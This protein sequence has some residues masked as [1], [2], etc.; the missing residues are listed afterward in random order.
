[1]SLL[2]SKKYSVEI[3]GIFIFVLVLVSN[4]AVIKF[5]EG[6][7]NYY[8]VPL[9][10][11]EFTPQ[12]HD[13][14]EAAVP[15]LI[16]SL[17]IVYIIWLSFRI[18]ENLANWLLDK[19]NIGLNKNL[20]NYLQHHERL[21]I[22]IANTLNF[23]ITAITIIIIIP[24][25]WTTITNAATTLGEQKAKNTSIMYSLSTEDNIKQEIIIHTNKNI[26]ITK[27]YDT[28]TR[29][30]IDGYRILPTNTEYDVRLI[31]K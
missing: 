19:M 16:V 29:K 12:I 5:E 20:Q 24:M 7:L 11:I 9:D 31:V 3:T 30:F 14:L 10:L 27:T 4:L 23:I 25:T 2:T 15:I 13:Y 1:M 17:F 18:G 6:Y 28:D 21:S 22:M 8:K 26:M